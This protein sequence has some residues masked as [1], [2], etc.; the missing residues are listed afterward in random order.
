MAPMRRIA[1]LSVLLLGGCGAGSESSGSEGLPGGGFVSPSPKVFGFTIRVLDE[2]GAAIGGAAVTIDGAARAT[3]PDGTLIVAGFSEPALLIVEAPGFLPEPVVL[4]P[5]DSAGLREIRLKADVGPGGPRRVFH[6]GGDIMLG[7]RYQEPIQPDTA[8]VLSDAEARAAVAPLAPLFRAA[9]VSMANL[10]TV[11][12][13]FPKAAA[14]PKKR[15]LLQSPP[16]MI[17]ALDELGL[18][19]AILGNNHVRDWLEPGLV[20]TLNHLST[21]GI[22]TV[23]AGA[24]EADAAKE[25][26]L[27]VGGLKVG[28]L[29]YTTIIGDFVNDAYP[30]DALPIPP[31]TSSAELWQ[32]EFRTW[33]FTG[34][35]VTIPTASRR[36]GSAWDFIKTRELTMPDGPEKNAMWAS[37][38]AVYPELQ[39]WAARRGHGGANNLVYA[40]MEADIARLKTVEGCDLVVVQLHA[41]HQYTDVCS[42]GMSDAAHR[43]IDAPGGG[44]DIVIG[45]HAHV[46]QGFEFYKGRLVCFSLGNCV[47]DQDFLSTFLTSVLRVVFEGT[48]MI[49]ARVYPMTLLRYRPTPVA[50]RAARN[51][52]KVLQ[53][54]SSLDARSDREGLGVIQ[55]VRPVVP[56]AVKPAF[57]LDGNS[58]L[59][60]EGPPAPADLD[61]TASFEAATELPQMGMVRSRGTGLNNILFG[62]DL[63][64]W[65]DFED[66]AADGDPLGGNQWFTFEPPPS[67]VVAVA[68]DAPSGSR[69]LRLYRRATNADRVR[70]R[71]VARVIRSERRLFFGANNPADGPASYSMRFKAKYTG[72]GATRFTFDVYNFDDANPSEDPDSI[73]LRSVEVAFT[74]PDDGLWHEALVDL[75][76][77]V[78]Q[79]FGSLPANSTMFYAGL[80]PPA[81]GESEFWLDDLQFIEWRDP[82]Q[83]P[84]GYFEATVIRLKA[85]GAP[86][87]VTLQHREK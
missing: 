27:D 84:D 23:G 52:L 6:F 11:I 33:G 67:A 63:F 76:A 85:P 5:E 73:L 22:P 54:R 57:T 24:N 16:S 69:A 37:A 82:L 45:H 41:G 17:A 25:A 87:A 71:P 39:D 80:H 51:I 64:R 34:A 81:S 70:L 3:L 14:Y 13:N 50:G 19:L 1:L 30:S 42:S 83:M 12:G 72:T 65:G 61:L 18:D 55:V 7:R 36:V 62:R 21:A 9:D 38:S 66:H 75:P 26:I 79:P 43:A 74:V 56:G 58:A 32:Y 20:S 4:G 35:T 60:T 47:F 29:S 59:L 48:S 77:V 53:E 44:A 15:F 49:E 28:V 86:A 78:F 68:D 8:L 40:K 2:G 10:E 31:G 46:Q